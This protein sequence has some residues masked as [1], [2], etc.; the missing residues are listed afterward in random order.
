MVQFGNTLSLSLSL[1][2]TYFQSKLRI[3]KQRAYFLSN[4]LKLLSKQT[5]LDLNSAVVPEQQLLLLWTYKP[6]YIIQSI[7]GIKYVDI[8]IGFSK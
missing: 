5:S 2:K 4:A 3:S 1:H 8:C 6:S 7:F